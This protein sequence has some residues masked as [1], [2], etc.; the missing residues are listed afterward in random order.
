MPVQLMSDHIFL[1][2]SVV[3][4]LSAELVLLRVN[5]R[6]QRK[7]LAAQLLGVAGAFPTL[8]F[9]SASGG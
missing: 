7:P 3:A 6:S 2:S 4:T 9:G 8:N 1:G 5:L